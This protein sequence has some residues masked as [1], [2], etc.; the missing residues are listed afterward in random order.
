[1]AT[2]PVTDPSVFA[3]FAGLDSL[4]R[5][6][7]AHD[8]QALRTVA[9][10]FES[11]FARM[12][13][14]SMRDAVGP[15][16][17]FGSDQER[18]Y[19]GMFD[20]Q[21]SVELTR[22]RGLGL[23]DMLIRQ[24]QR[25]G[26]DS[27]GAVDGSAAGTSEAADGSAAGKPEAALGSKGGAKIGATVGAEES[28]GSIG[29]HRSGAAIRSSGAAGIRAPHELRSIAHRTT[30]PASVRSAFIS[31]IWPHAAQAA[32]ELGVSP[33]SLVAQ[34]ALETNWGRDVP[35]DAVGRSSHN[36]FGI[37]AGAAWSGRDV[38]ATTREFAGDAAHET[39][40]AFRAYDG[41]AESFA[42]YVA[43]L[44]GN[45]RYA[46]ALGT[47]GDV[48]AFAAAL[49]RGGYATDPDYARKVTAVAASVAGLEPAALAATGQ[50]ARSGA[51]KL[52]D[53]QPMNVNTRTL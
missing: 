2:L 6:A 38:S 5:A 34:A 48:Q 49:Q 17:I 13:L 24:L 15:D 33:T 44:R 28:S 42:D 9:K 16:P 21:L 35:R 31:R 40:A 27:S 7:R 53:A 1:M 30:G 47:G 36:L 43:L 4:K 3:D 12:M 46:A 45:P 25:L 14:K 41:P 32:R 20:D 29:M 11:L 18:M 52:A 39:H 37:K 51:L 26:V 50:A 8:P 23:A 22:G 19:Q 10:Q